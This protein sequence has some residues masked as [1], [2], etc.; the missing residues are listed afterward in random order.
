MLRASISSSGSGLTQTAVIVV[1]LMLCPGVAAVGASGPAAAVDRAAAAAPDRAVLSR[2]AADLAGRAE[3]ERFAAARLLASDSGPQGVLNRTPGIALMGMDRRGRPLFLQA[4]NLNSALTVGADRIWPGGATGLDL[5]GAGVQG[6]LGIWDVGAVRDDHLEF[7]GR[8]VQVDGYSVYGDHATHVAGTMIAAG[9]DPLA[10]GIAPAA[11]LSAWDWINDSGEMAAAAADGLRVSNH[12]YGATSGWYQAG[13]SG[14]W[15]WFGDPT[16]DPVEDYGFGF[17]SD[18]TRDW[19]LVAWNA[20]GYLIVKSAGNDRDDTGPAA[21]QP[22]YVFS[23][24]SWTQ[25]VAVR[26][27]DG[28]PD[29]YDSIARC[30]TAKNVLTVGAVYDIPGGYV[31]SASVSIS[32]FSSWGPTDDGRIKPDLV[33]DGV[34]VWSAVAG[35]A[36]SYAAYNGTSSAAP[37]VAATAAVV[38]D[39]LAAARQS[40]PWASTLKA[41]LIHTADEAGEYPGP[42]YRYGW[43]LLDADGAAELAAAAAVDPNLVREAWLTA[44]RPDTVHLV[45]D[46]AGPILATICWTDPPGESPEPQVDPD[47]RILVNDLDLRIVQLANGTVSRPWVLDPAAPGAAAMQ[48]DNSLDNVEMVYRSSPDPGDYLAI[49]SNDGELAGGGQVYSL[50]TTGAQVR[51]SAPVIANLRFGQSAAGGGVVE[52]EFDIVD[53]DSPTVDILIFAS[54]DGGLSW[55]LAV[56][57]IS[58][59]VGEGVAV[60]AD[61]LVIWDFAA[62]NPGRFGRDFTVRV[63]ADDGS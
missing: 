31:D 40:A 61:K 30:G 29:G 41:I 48:G 57:T 19:D 20:P 55:D 15:Y 47:D 22:H 12:S 52:I 37:A 62:D 50:V 26:D 56:T 28:G 18:K 3:V 7:G 60:G 17:Y 38:A 39:Q 16:V 34:G 46:G 43:G 5:D 63:V 10:R 21:G 27:P 54:D 24:G 36:D 49:I 13:G 32:A 14:V 6:E 2:I 53:V 35:A 8:V 1:L 25:S 45:S 51:G 44:D 33:A 59:D 42:D 58:G 23:A 9:A 4:H 11:H